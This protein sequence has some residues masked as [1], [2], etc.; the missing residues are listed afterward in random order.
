MPI[1]QAH[2]VIFI[3]VPKNAGTS[4][5][6]AFQMSDF[7]HHYYNYYVEKYPAQWSAYQKFAIIRN[8]WD[9][10]VSCYEYA[11]MQESYWHSVTG[12]ARYNVHP[13]YETLKD[14]SF[15]ETV[16]LFFSGSIKL[17]H[18]GWS[19]QHDY[20]INNA[21]NICVDF[22][23]QYDNVNHEIKSRFGVELPV[24][25]KSKR[26]EYKS[27][28]THDLVEKIA[29]IYQKDIKKFNFKYE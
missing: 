22:L 20:I 21:G 27:Y 18:Q 6:D 2:K 16:D 24:V 29:E 14:L 28:Y 7:G 11:R 25:N 17:K 13:D 12:K 4:I 26:L 15:K 10:F 9:R 19:L 1:S 3:H 8:P 5:T 23:I